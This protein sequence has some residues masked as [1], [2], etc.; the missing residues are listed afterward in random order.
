MGKVARPKRERGQGPPPVRK[1][2]TRPPASRAT[3]IVAVVLGAALIAGLAAY[4]A[5][6]G[7]GAAS[8]SVVQSRL[9]HATLGELGSYWPPN[10]ENLPA[11]MSA[12]DLPIADPPVLH[13]HDHLDLYVDGEQ[14]VVPA[15]I[16]L[17]VEAEVPLHTHDVSGI[18]HVESSSKT[19]K[20]TLGEFFDAWGLYLSRDCIGGYCQGGGK[21]LWVFVNGK[22]YPGDP[23][24]I[25][26]RQHDEIVLAYGTRAQLP[27]PLPRSYRFPGGL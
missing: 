19:L 3:L 17:S 11:L 26:L 2:G 1:K 22:P 4:L 18:I 14:T 27:K 25:P 6:Q 23:T 5:S 20:P 8:S 9:S 24:E 13:H 21:R 15:N 16:G 7:G 10:Q 12:L